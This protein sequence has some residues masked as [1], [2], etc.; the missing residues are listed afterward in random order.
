MVRV[1]TMIVP[2][3]LSTVIILGIAFIAISPGRLG[4][5]R[6]LDGSAAPGGLSEKL[7]IEIGG[8]RQGMIIRSAD[9]RNP[10]LLFVHGG[11]GMPEAFLDARYPTGL[12]RH[13]TVCWWDQRGA[14]L[15]YTGEERYEDITSDRL[16]ADTIEVADYL[17]GRF[18]VDRV[19][20]LAHSWGT[21]IGVQAAARAPDRFHAYIAVA[22][23]SDQSRS[24][25]DAYQ[26]MLGEYE[27]RGDE[28]ALKALGAYAGF[29]SDR[30]LLAAYSESSA[31]DRSMHELGIGTMRGMRSVVKGIFLPVMGCRGYTAREK[32]DLWVAKAR[33]KERTDLRRDLLGVDLRATVTALAIPTYF[34]S[35]AYDR[36]VSV[37]LAK[38]YLDALEAPVK[39]F[40]T[41]ADSAHSP[42]FEEP[43]RFV[44]VMTAD[45]L[46][47]R[48]DLADR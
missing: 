3:L 24:E 36:T 28:R 11:P 48:T 32:I 1:S 14:G 42:P 46:R 23:V 4:P 6:G 20:L 35:G 8:V 43:G 45:V 44:D 38:G 13:F 5:V 26:Y 27:R 47:G 10:V 39:G 25:L 17:R 19:Y 34:V 7:F 30:A 29:E 40:Y 41:F 22:Q 15:S 33:L 12:E 37:D 31:R 9:A 18:G 2:A 21:F 16:V